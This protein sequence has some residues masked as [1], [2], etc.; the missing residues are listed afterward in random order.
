MDGCLGWHVSASQES[1]QLFNYWAPEGCN[2]I[3]ENHFFN[4]LFQC[5]WPPSTCKDLFLSE[6]FPPFL[7]FERQSWL[8]SAL[9]LPHVPFLTPLC[10]FTSFP[11]LSYQILITVSCSRVSSAQKPR[12]NHLVHQLST[13]DI[14]NTY[15][16]IRF[17]ICEL[18]RSIF[19]TELI[20]GFQAY[21][22]GLADFGSTHTTETLMKNCNSW[23][24][25]LCFLQVDAPSLACTGRNQ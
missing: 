11:D 24:V 22:C 9:W 3:S 18:L 14:L 4:P 15:R 10:L 25:V 13:V 16:C 1:V 5:F 7:F 8:A 6:D 12:L 20:S 17:F 21:V 23:F 2:A 19:P